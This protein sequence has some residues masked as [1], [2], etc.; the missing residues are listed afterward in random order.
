MHRKACSDLQTNTLSCQ[1][2]VQ[3]SKIAG[4]RHS[5]QCREQCRDEP[6]V[7]PLFETCEQ[8]GGEPHVWPSP[9]NN[10]SLQSTRSCTSTS[11]LACCLFV[12]LEA[13]LTKVRPNFSH[14]AVSITCIAG[15]WQARHS[16]EPHIWPFLGS[17]RVCNRQDL[18]RQ[19]QSRHPPYAGCSTPHFVC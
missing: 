15:V 5:R 12:L 1:P 13:R 10:P 11:R 6:R 16:C 14:S 18:A 4:I 9:G 3:A 8:Y 7:W 19:H 17:T 2:A